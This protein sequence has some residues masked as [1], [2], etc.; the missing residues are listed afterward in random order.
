MRAKAG[1]VID[2]GDEVPLVLDEAGDGFL[3]AIIGRIMFQVGGAFRRRVLL[4][5]DSGV[6]AAEKVG[7][8]VR[9][10]YRHDRHRYSHSRPAHNF[11]PIVYMNWP[12]ND[13]REGDN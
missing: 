6:L 12:D 10:R 5:Q 11:L 8:A 1:Q 2:A 9:A 3:A 13:R 7:E 4:R